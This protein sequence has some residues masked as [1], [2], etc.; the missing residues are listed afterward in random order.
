M[1]EIPNGNRHF[2][3]YT[4]KWM[5]LYIAIGFIAALLLPFPASLVAAIG[6][7]M[8]VNFLRTRLM[9]KKMGIGMKG[10]FGSLRSS[11]ASPSMSGY[12]PIKYYCMSCGNEHKE[13]ACPKCGSKM[14][15]VG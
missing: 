9:L 12:S 3:L 13:I 11:D 2:L 4:L 10:L 7:F 8:L 14:K 6:G 5:S 15:R 1:N